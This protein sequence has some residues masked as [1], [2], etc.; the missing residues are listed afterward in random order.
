MLTKE[1]L[2][3]VLLLRKR[4]NPTSNQPPSCCWRLAF[5]WSLSPLAARQQLAIYR[6]V[7][8]D[9]CSRPFSFTAGLIEQV[10]AR[11]LLLRPSTLT[12]PQ[13]MNSLGEL[14]LHVGRSIPPPGCLFHRLLTAFYSVQHSRLSCPVPNTSLPYKSSVGRKITVSVSLPDRVLRKHGPWKRIRSRIRISAWPT[15]TPRE[16][17]LP[18][19]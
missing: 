7:D 12:R 1:W 10:L 6:T 18:V 9:C 19:N 17:S 11:G 2:Y 15:H 3:G 14:L 5:Y 8:T 4:T 13:P 16:Q